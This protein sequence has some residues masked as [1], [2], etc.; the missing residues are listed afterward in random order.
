ML[1]GGTIPFHF[2]SDHGAVLEKLHSLPLS[3]W[4]SADTGRRLSI[5][6]AVQNVLFFVPF[7]VLGMLAAG[8]KS[9]RAFRVLLV[10]AAGA[11]LSLFVEV[12]QLFESDRVASTADLM[13]NT[14]GAFA[15]AVMALA[16]R[17]AVLAGFERLRSAGLAGVR[18]FRPLAIWSV[19]LLVT[20][21]Q[22][23][24]VTLE[25][26]T[27]ATKVRSLQSNL[28]Q[29]SGIRD[30]GLL[31]LVT[32]L[33]AMSLASY[34][35]AIGIARPG[36]RAA[37]AGALLAC[38]LEAS[39]ILITSRMPSG[40]DMA[41]LSS[42]ILVGVSLWTLST[43]YRSRG[44]ELT[45]LTIATAVAAA[46]AMLSP[47]QFTVTSH[48]MG[49]YPLLAYYSRTTF[50][51]VSHVIELLLLYFPLGYAFG[52][53]VPPERRWQ[54]AALGIALAIAAPVEALQGWVIGRYPDVSDLA[55]SLLGAWI[56]L[57][58]G[59]TES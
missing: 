48:N 35:R 16:G 52:A 42:G 53:L 14:A 54:A 47:F 8:L 13:T 46:L 55:I 27:V 30:E 17:S 57:I 36:T 58:V 39:Q 23:F 3:P 28:W 7:G 26:G 25:L 18:E 41:V 44:V 2:A 12:L 11:A 31:L 34:F 4:V 59:R 9:M 5:P 21:W 45:L 40:W 29:F 20:A 24:D 37:L 49:W 6:D 22:P 33:F 32:S 1:Y 51:A 50:E 56:G 38:A 15:G 10:T 43:R 19:V